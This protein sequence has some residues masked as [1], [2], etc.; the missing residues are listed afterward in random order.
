MSSNG[1]APDGP[2]RAIILSGPS[3]SKDEDITKECRILTVEQ[4]IPYS[5]FSSIVPFDSD[6][7]PMPSIGL[8]SSNSIFKGS[9]PLEESRYGL[10]NLNREAADPI[11]SSGNLQRCLSYVGELLHPAGITRYKF[12][13]KPKS[14]TN[15]SDSQEPQVFLSAFTQM[16]FENTYL[17]FTNSNSDSYLN[18]R[19]SFDLLRSSPSLSLSSRHQPLSSHHVRQHNPLLGVS[20]RNIIPQVIIPSKLSERKQK[21]YSEH[22]TSPHLTSISETKCQLEL[23]QKNSMIKNT[24]GDNISNFTSDPQINSS[25]DSSSLKI[26]NI[27]I[28]QQPVI[29]SNLIQKSNKPDRGLLKSV[30]KLKIQDNKIPSTKSDAPVY[31]ENIIPRL[32][33]GSHN[34]NLSRECDERERADTALRNLQEFLQE[35]LEVENQLDTDTVNQFFTYSHE[36]GIRLTVSTH[37]KLDSLIQKAIQLGRFSKVE[38]SDLIRVQRICESTLKDTESLDLKIHDQMSEEDVKLWSLQ[39]TSAQLSIRSAY[40]ALRIMSGSREERQIYSEDLTKSALCAFSYVLEVCVIPILEIRNFGSF[41]NLFRLLLGEKKI[42]ISLFKQCQRLLLLLATLVPQVD[43]ADSVMNALESIIFKIFFVENVSSEKDSIIGTSRFD[44]MR[45]AAMEVLLGIFTSRPAQRRGIFAEFLTSL[46]KLPISKQNARQFKLSEGGIIQHASALIMRLIQTNTIRLD[47][48][49]ESRRMM[50]LNDIIPNNKI[51]TDYKHD[52]VISSDSKDKYETNSTTKINHLKVIVAPL[53]K[54]AK[55]DATYVIEFIVNRATTTTKGIESPYRHLLDFFVQDFITCLGSIDW[56]SAELLLRFLLFKM[57]EISK[58]PKASSISRNMALDVLSQMGPK[59]S[60]LNFQAQKMVKSVEYYQNELGNNLAK[61]MELFFEKKESDAQTQKFDSEI[62]SWSHGPFRVCLESLEDRSSENLVSDSAIAF[63]KVDWANRII[64]SFDRIEDKNKELEKN[65]EILAQRIQG[66]IKDDKWFTREYGFNNKPTSTEIR[67]A[68]TLILLS[69]PFCQYLDHILSIFFTSMNSGQAMV[70]AKSLKCLT[71]LL[72]TDPSIIERHPWVKDQMVA[73]LEDISSSVRENALGLVSKL[74]FLRPSLEIEMVPEVLKRLSDANVG[75]RKRAIKLSKDIYIRNLKHHVRVRIAKTL[76]W[77]TADDEPSIQELARQ[78]LE[79]I[80]LSP[81]HQS[82]ANNDISPQFKL[83]RAELVSLIVETTETP[84][85]MLDKLLADKLD[86]AL[87]N[88]LSSTSKSYEANATV[89]KAL[90]ESMFETVID[91]SSGASNGAQSRIGCFHILQIFATSKPELFTIE[92]I[93]I[94]HPYVANLSNTDNAAIYNSVVNIF[95][96]T[97]PHLS[98]IQENLLI[99]IRNDLL[100]SL[101]RLRVAQLDDVIACMSIISKT[102]R[103]FDNLTRVLISGLETINKLKCSELKEDHAL[104]KLLKLLPIVG[105]LGKHCDF[106]SRRSELSKKFPLPQYGTV[107]RLITDIIAPL[108]SK[109]YPLELRKSALQALG[110]VCFSWPQN[111]SYMNVYSAF[112][113]AFDEKQVELEMVVLE[114][115]KSF[116][117]SEEKRSELEQENPECI[118]IDVKANL[119]V[120]GGSQ[121]DGIALSIAQRFLQRI[122]FV[123]LSSREEKLTLLSTEI[124]ASVARQGLVHPKQPGVAL[125]ILETAP[126]MKVAKIAYDEHIALHAKH[127]TLFERDYMTAVQSSYDYQRDIVNDTRGAW[128]SNDNEI[129]GT[130]Y[131]SKLSRMIQVLNDFSKPKTRKKFFENICLQL[132]KN[133]PRKDASEKHLTSREDEDH[134]RFSQYLVEN[135]AFFDYKTFDELISIIHVIEKLVSSMGTDVA[136]AIENDVCMIPLHNPPL[137]NENNENFKNSF[138]DVNFIRLK[139][140]TAASIP[141]L[142]LWEVRSFL[143]QQHGLISNKREGRAKVSKDLTIKPSKIAGVNGENFWQQSNVISGALKSVESMK[144]QCRKFVELLNFDHELKVAASSDDDSIEPRITPE[145][146]E[147][148]S[149]PRTLHTSGI[150]QSKK[151][152]FFNGTLSPNHK[153]HQ[154]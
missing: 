128:I 123:S 113:Q 16:V 118:S 8:R 81:L 55:S 47:G 66:V 2:D 130:S 64:E 69:S 21:S 4:A 105:L 98:G 73:R 109:S 120:M 41:K 115:F 112:E 141:L 90:V 26:S 61:L 147:E 148:N 31:P 97:L 13:V 80:W 144:D 110:Y 58:S 124:I 5:P 133:K 88:I 132:D 104:K 36:H 27:P 63:I 87:T 18:S 100:K 153:K 75:V 29:S 30:G 24:S 48:E 46:E 74:I 86:K 67:L 94:L 85:G 19:K 35:I 125:I 37:I 38:V 136:H 68:H 25:T 139:Q 22:I 11:N 108:A 54:A 93:Q 84:D 12:K 78:T 62:L 140:L 70:Q 137:S 101:A 91:N 39:L 99:T 7:I 28:T 53:L 103:N 52:C 138:E 135:I 92:H 127:E 96:Q 102:L 3:N 76:L 6:I 122:I 119:G 121:G 60:E 57:I 83:D 111:F 34:D 146:D 152:K 143:R 59:I 131:V 95:K 89:F 23:N 77:K 107:S 40:T 14:C 106:E 65:Y 20:T 51:I 45:T 72:D 129:S 126:F 17:S 15:S 50:I 42:V 145:I 150:T 10:E 149:V 9:Y 142:L 1:H 71:Q 79:D 32:E 44:R 56:P 82:A 117:L 49:K 151:R 154:P 114:A 116:L 134:M 43:L 33:I